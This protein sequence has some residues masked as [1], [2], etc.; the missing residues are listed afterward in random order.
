MRIIGD[1]TL[2]VPT[3]TVDDIKDDSMKT[4]RSIM[5]G[6]KNARDS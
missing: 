2:S 5:S 4:C 1:N 3:F 6:M